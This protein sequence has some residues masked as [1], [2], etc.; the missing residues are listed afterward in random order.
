MNL[1]KTQLNF[2]TDKLLRSLKDDANVKFKVEESK[3]KAKILEVIFSN[4]EEEKKIELEAKN[5]LKENEAIIQKDNLNY[6]KL[7]QATKK[8]IAKD[9]GFIL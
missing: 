2:L 6:A 9:K 4:Q 7:F 8:K 1:N 5:L 3:I